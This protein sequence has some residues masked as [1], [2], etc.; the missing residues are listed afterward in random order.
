MDDTLDS[1]HNLQPHFL[2]LW[3]WGDVAVE[4]NDLLMQAEQ[5]TEYK[6]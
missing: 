3:S 4:I 2:L 6:Y 1:V 5:Q